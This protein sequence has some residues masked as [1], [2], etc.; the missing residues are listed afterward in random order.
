MVR[1]KK[2]KKPLPKALRVV[3]RIFQTAG[4][5]VLAAV[6]LFLIF[7]GNVFFYILLIAFI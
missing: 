5:I 4:M 6:I 2:A 7:F 3:K 1:A